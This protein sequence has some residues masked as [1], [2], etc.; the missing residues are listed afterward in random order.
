MALVN[1]F[2]N[3]VFILQDMGYENAYTSFLDA[4]LDLPH[5]LMRLNHLVSLL[6]HSDLDHTCTYR[7][8]HSDY[9][10]AEGSTMALIQRD[11]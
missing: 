3:Y 5:V 7:A 8:A 2:Y 6:I 11:L 10:V 1:V 4:F 9:T